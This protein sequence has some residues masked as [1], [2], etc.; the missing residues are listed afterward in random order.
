MPTY[1]TL[2]ITLVPGLI[3][4]KVGLLNPAFVYRN[5]ASTNI[6]ETFAR[7]RAEQAGK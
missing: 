1:T 6:R 7:I 2:P 5:A 3:T 4:P